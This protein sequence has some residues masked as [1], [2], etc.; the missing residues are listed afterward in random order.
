MILNEGSGVAGSVQPLSES[1]SNIRKFINYLKHMLASYDHGV[2]V[3]AGDGRFMAL[4]SLVCDG[5][6]W[7][8]VELGG[9]RVAFATELF[10]LIRR[11]GGNIDCKVHHDNATR[12]A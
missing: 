1:P 4:C 3:G 6:R 5:Q 2:D 8:G 10:E 12:W 11:V 7:T 9:T